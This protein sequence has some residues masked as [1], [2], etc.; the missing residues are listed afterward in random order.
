MRIKERSELCIKF[1][2]LIGVRLFINCYVIS[3]H[4]FSCY[5]YPSYHMYVYVIGFS[6]LLDVLE[7]RPR[8]PF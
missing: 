1:I 8:P 5:L 4:W 6:Y 2:G 3:L 7:Y